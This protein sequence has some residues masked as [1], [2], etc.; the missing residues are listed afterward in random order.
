MGVLKG[1]RKKDK[2]AQE[3]IQAH[4]VDGLKNSNPTISTT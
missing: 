3:Y 4:E 2:F 1:K